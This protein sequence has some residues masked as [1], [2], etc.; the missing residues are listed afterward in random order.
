MGTKVSGLSTDLISLI[1][2][3]ALITIAVS[4]YVVLFGSKIYPIFQ[5]ILFERQTTKQGKGNSDDHEV[6]LF[7]CNRIGSDFLE[8]FKDQG[9]K[10]LVVDYD[11]E[12]IDELEKAGI[13]C[14]YGDADD[15]EFLE[16]L[17]LGKSKMVISTIPDF[18]TNQ[19][20]IGKIRSENEE[21]V[22]MV[23]SHD[24]DEAIGLYESGATY[25]ITPHL[26]GGKYASML[27]SKFGFD[28][29]KFVG[30]KEKHLKDLEK[31]KELG[32]TIA[33][34]ELYR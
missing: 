9:R 24:V 25:V 27:I 30:E 14:R 22:V 29:S 26:L 28:V 13:N 7:G 15:N 11:P 12:K 21:V 17:N 32:A 18:E 33:L 2:L 8:I 1:T 5:N 34:P 20:L 3:V 19:F 16:E 6:V 23:I 10:F 4:S 31:K